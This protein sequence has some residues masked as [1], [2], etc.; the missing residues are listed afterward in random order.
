MVDQ[1]R[2][3]TIN[4]SKNTKHIEEESNAISNK[5]EHMAIENDMFQMEIVEG[6]QFVLVK[7]VIRDL[8]LFARELTT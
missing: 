7:I 4:R 2:D 5:Y 3:I 6:K 8:I 1:E